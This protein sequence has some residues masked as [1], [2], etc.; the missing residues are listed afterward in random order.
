MHGIFQEYNRATSTKFHKNLDGE[1]KFKWVRSP[2][3]RST[4]FMNPLFY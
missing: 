2:K 3:E 4:T 1:W